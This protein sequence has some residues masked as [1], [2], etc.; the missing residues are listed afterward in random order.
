MENQAEYE[1]LRGSTFFLQDNKEAEGQVAAWLNE[2]LP[3]DETK[4]KNSR[5][6]I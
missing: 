4:T 3:R 6:E 1:F 5:A 2:P